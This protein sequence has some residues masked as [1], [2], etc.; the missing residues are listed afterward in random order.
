MV[1]AKRTPAKDCPPQIKEDEEKTVGTT[2]A[3]NNPISYGTTPD[4]FTASFNAQRKISAGDRTEVRIPVDYDSQDNLLETGLEMLFQLDEIYVKKEPFESGRYVLL[5]GN[6]DAIFT[7][8]IYHEDECL[9][10]Y[11]SF[12]MSV[13]K[14]NDDVSEPVQ[15]FDIRRRRACESVALRLVSG[16]MFGNNVSMNWTNGKLVG[17]IFQL[18]HCCRPTFEAE[19]AVGSKILRIQGGWGGGSCNPLWACNV[20]EFDIFASSTALEPS[21]TI[22]KNLRP[23]NFTSEHNMFGANFPSDLDPLAKVLIIGALFQLNITYFER[24]IAG[25]DVCIIFRYLVFLGVII[26]LV[27][28]VQLGIIQQILFSNKEQQEQSV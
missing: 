9:G 4:S 1:N 17:Q 8:L 12:V 11:R 25:M 18:R 15:V 14:V 19:N 7:A 27:I 6:G 2:Q 22:K 21:G 26:A 16:S 3:S 20:S 28:A 23:F 5:N 13:A 24:K 10:Q